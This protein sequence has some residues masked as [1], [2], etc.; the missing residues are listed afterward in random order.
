MLQQQS[1]KIRQVMVE[2]PGF[3][4]VK[5]DTPSGLCSSEFG[6]SGTTVE[7]HPGNGGSYTIFPK[8]RSSSTSC[9]RIE[10]DGTAVYYPLR[11]VDDNEAHYYV[12]RHSSDVVV[13]TID[14]IG[15]HYVVTRTGDNH[16]GRC[17][18]L[19]RGY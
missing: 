7:C 14:D 10:T 1:R 15:Y 18:H 5:F 6:S 19:V 3:A 9:L 13:E 4:T 2:C 11:Q 16:V 8:D 12:M 17:D